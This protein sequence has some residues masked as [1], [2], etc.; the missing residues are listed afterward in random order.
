MPADLGG[1]GEVG[2]CKQALPV[3]TAEAA[4]NADGAVVAD[5]AVPAG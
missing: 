3:G 2:V 5:E 4:G 1:A